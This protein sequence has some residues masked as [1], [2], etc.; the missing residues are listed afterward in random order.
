MNRARL[1]TLAL[2]MS[3]PM[4]LMAYNP[5]H[6]LAATGHAHLMCDG[7]AVTMTVTSL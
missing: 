1:R 7:H 5:V 6:A 3:T 4:A 2:V